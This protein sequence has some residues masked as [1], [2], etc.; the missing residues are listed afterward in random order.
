MSQ[1][2]LTAIV[3]VRSVGQGRQIESDVEATMR[4]LFFE[5]CKRGISVILLD[6]C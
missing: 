5:I 4:L 2:L 6:D 1:R 3:K